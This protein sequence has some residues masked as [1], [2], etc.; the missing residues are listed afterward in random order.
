MAIYFNKNG[1]TKEIATYQSCISNISVSDPNNWGNTYTSSNGSLKLTVQSNPTSLDRDETV[2]ISYKAGS[3]N[4]TKT[5][6]ISQE[7][8]TPTPVEAVFTFCDSTKTKTESLD[9][10]STAITYCVTSTSGSSILPYSISNSCSWLNV[11]TASTGIRM[12]VSPNDGLLRQCSFNLV[13]SETS[14]ILTVNVTQSGGI[15][16]TCNYFLDSCCGVDIDVHPDYDIAMDGE[17]VSPAGADSMHTGCT[18]HLSG[19]IPNW[20]SV[21]IDYNAATVYYNALEANETGWNRYYELQFT[22]DTDT[23]GNNYCPSADVIVKH[24]PTAESSASVTTF[25]ALAMVTNNSDST[26]T[27]SGLSISLEDIS[28][29]T[30]PFSATIAAGE[31]YTAS[32]SIA[33][34]YNGVDMQPSSVAYPIKVRFT[35]NT[36]AYAS[37]S[38]RTITEGGTYIIAF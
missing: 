30:V 1:E 18:F 5:V 38:N 26:K 4:C 7:A 21:D 29:F 8:N 24:M 32:M 20:M 31:T 10:G 34:A 35:D 6:D 2:T 11:S 13:Q 37:C 22:L 16:P 28:Y 17:A 33:S 14:D 27:I 19:G 25:N 3:T 9:S 12:V 23:S 36:W 15:E